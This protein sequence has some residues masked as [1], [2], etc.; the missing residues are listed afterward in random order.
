MHRPRKLIL[1][2]SFFFYR[3]GDTQAITSIGVVE[4]YQTMDDVDAIVARVKR[5][6]VYS[7]PEISE[8]SKKPT[9]VMLFR[10]VRHL[11]QNVGITDLLS[12]GLLKGPPQSITRINDEQ[13]RKICSMA[14]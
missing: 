12:C 8:M 9:K 13:F 14:D 6:T 11:A 3:S 5:R 7:L 1:V 10:F 4:S 2:T